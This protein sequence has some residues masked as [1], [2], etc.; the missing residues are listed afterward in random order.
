MESTDRIKEKYDEWVREFLLPTLKKLPEW[1]K[2]A[3][4]FGIDVKALYTPLD[5]KGDYLDKL[6]FPG[7]YPFTRVYTQACIG[8]GFG[9]S[10][11]TQALV[12]L[13]IRI[14]GISSSYRRDRRV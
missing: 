5:I 10:G 12:R 4:S 6:G 14:G 9:R 2:F 11:N 1:R 3:T 13:R 7:E 8:L